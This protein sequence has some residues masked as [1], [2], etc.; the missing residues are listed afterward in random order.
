[1]GKIAK[2]LIIGAC[3][4]ITLGIVLVVGGVIGGGISGAKAILQGD[5]MLGIITSVHSEDFNTST[6]HT[7]PISDGDEPGLTLDLGAGEFEI[8]ESDGTD[9]V[10]KSKRKMNVSADG[11]DIVIETP[12][13]D[14]FLNFIGNNPHEV[15]IEVP[16]GTEFDDIVMEVGAGELTCPGLLCESLIMEI[17]AGRISVE[18]FTCKEAV[19]SVGAGEIIVEN[20]TAGEMN[21]EVGMGNFVFEGSVQGDLDADCGMGNVQMKVTGNEKDYNYQIDC[22]MG[23][24]T[25][26]SHSYSGIGAEQDIDNGASSDFD[27]DCGMGNLEIRFT[28]E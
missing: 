28:E 25:V 19:I 16:R 8:V 10:I 12:N 9:I 22:D 5:T 18:D 27:L 13:E 15:T 20:G 23:N 6:E 7:I 26:G 24:V 4:S 1:M 3:V 21:V 17:G 14:V 11:E 2:G